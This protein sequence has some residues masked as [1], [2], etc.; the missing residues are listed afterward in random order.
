MAE[1][2]IGTLVAVAVPVYALF[3][4]V[5]LIYEE[6]DPS[7]TLA[8][9]LFLLLVPGSWT[10][11]LPAVRPQLAGHRQ[12]RRPASRSDS[13]RY[14]RSSHRSTRAGPPRRRPSLPSARV[15]PADRLGDREPERHATAAVHR[16][17]DLRE[18]RRQVPAAL[19]RHRGGDGLGPPRVLHLG[20]RR[21]DRPLLRPARREGPRRASRCACSTTGWARC[22]T[23]SRS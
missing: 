14:R 3:V 6:R 11:L 19:R 9:A 4:I 17:R 21:A 8:W 23:A 16:A 7:T 13:A 20:E 12:A 1:T 5:L 22:P 15:L 10:R 18:G 2:L